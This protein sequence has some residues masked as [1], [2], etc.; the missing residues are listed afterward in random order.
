VSRLATVELEGAFGG[1]WYAKIRASSEA[2][3]L[4]KALAPYRDGDWVT[5]AVVS[6]RD[7]RPT[8]PRL[9]NIPT[10]ERDR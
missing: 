2:E 1:L 10:M 3:A 9:S 5:A 7:C 6:W 4:S 8:A